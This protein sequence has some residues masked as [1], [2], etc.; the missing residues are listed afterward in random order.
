MADGEGDIAADRWTGWAVAAIHRL[1]SGD[2]VRKCNEKA[3]RVLARHPS[4]SVRGNWLPFTRLASGAMG[5]DETRKEESCALRRLGSDGSGRPVFSLPLPL[6]FRQLNRTGCLAGAAVLDAGQRGHGIGGGAS[7]YL[8]TS[9]HRRASPAG[10]AFRV[11]QPGPL[12]AL[13]RD[14]STAWLC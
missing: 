11:Q 4:F 3:T 8:K 2:R 13:R 12:T 1:L 14:Q 7:Y 5:P 9:P 6:L 10:P